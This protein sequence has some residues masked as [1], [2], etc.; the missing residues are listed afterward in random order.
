M[1]PPLPTAIVHRCSRSLQPPRR[2]RPPPSVV[3]ALPDGLDVLLAEIVVI[4]EKVKEEHEELVEKLRV[5]RDTQDELAL[6]FRTLQG[7]TPRGPGKGGKQPQRDRN[8]RGCARD[9]GGRDGGTQEGGAG[10]EPRARRAEA[11]LGG[12]ATSDGKVKAGVGRKRG[13]T[14]RPKQ[15]SRTSSCKKLSLSM[16]RATRNC[17]PPRARQSRWRR[18]SRCPFSSWP[19]Y[20]STT[21]CSPKRLARLKTNG[22]SF[23]TSWRSCR[24]R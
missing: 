4:A 5:S 23:A 19:R 8:G 9:Q 21:T 16:T 15:S 10:P 22:S 17:T 12:R 1:R 20:N 13:E 7:K 2:R 24:S 3:V 14:S 11:A 6:D 18:S